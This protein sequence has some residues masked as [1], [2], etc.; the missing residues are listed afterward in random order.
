MPSRLPRYL[1]GTLLVLI[2]LA[3]GWVWL[4]LHWNYSE[5]ERSEEHNV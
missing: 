3:V 2:L 1:I 5:G 4:T